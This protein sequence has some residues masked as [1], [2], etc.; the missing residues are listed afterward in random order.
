MH[1]YRFRRNHSTAYAALYIVDY[2]NYKMGQNRTLLNFDLNLPNDV[3]IFIV[4]ELRQ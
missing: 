1:Q 3:V 4:L 2:L